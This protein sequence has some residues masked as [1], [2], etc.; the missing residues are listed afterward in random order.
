[1]RRRFK[2]RKD[3]MRARWFSQAFKVQDGQVRLS[4]ATMWYVMSRK[5][6]GA[7]KE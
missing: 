6:S 5:I 2:K 3:P 7:Y 4:Y 1:M